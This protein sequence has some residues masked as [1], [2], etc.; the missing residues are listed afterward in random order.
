[1]EISLYEVPTYIGICE[2]SMTHI[3]KLASAFL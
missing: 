3:D 1:M 2:R